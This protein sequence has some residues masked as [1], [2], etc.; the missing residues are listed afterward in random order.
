MGFLAFGWLGLVLWFV[1]CGFFVCYVEDG[2]TTSACYHPLY[3]QTHLSFIGHLG[4]DAVY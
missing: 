2:D 1:L 3:V 4:I